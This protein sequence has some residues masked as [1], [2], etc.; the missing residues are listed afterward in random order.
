MGRYVSLHLEFEEPNRESD[1]LCSLFH[2]DVFQPKGIGAVGDEGSDSS[3]TTWFL[4]GWGLESFV[5]KYAGY[6]ELRK[7]HDFVCHTN[8]STKQED[9]VKRL[10]GYIR[11]GGRPT[12]DLSPFESLDATYACTFLDAPSLDESTLAECDNALNVTRNRIFDLCGTFKV[13]VQDP[14]HGDWSNAFRFLFPSEPTSYIPLGARF[15]TLN[16]RTEPSEPDVTQVHL[17]SEATIWLEHAEALN[18]SVGKAAADANLAGLV[19]IAETLVSSKNT[20]LRSA[21]LSIQSKTF[22]QESQRIE[23]AFE[24]V[25][26]S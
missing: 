23:K 13:A 25:L 2:C 18:G 24:S 12:R 5:C 3:H 9:Y 21:R 4:G 19:E 8:E 15:V 16:A 22:R 14:A 11:Q 20:R 17:F 7:S 1:V 26:T 10:V 6:A